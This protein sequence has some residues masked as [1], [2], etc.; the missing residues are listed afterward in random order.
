MCSRIKLQVIKS[1]KSL[2]ISQILVISAFLNVTLLLTIFSSAFFNI[3]SEKSKIRNWPVNWKSYIPP[4]P[5]TILEIGL[6]IL[7]FLDDS[8][9]LNVNAV[10]DDN[11]VCVVKLENT[12]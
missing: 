8:V 12:P 6:P 11:P 9:V 2:L 1:A 3:S 5:I 7:I 10:G 4:S